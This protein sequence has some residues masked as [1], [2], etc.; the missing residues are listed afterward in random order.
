MRIVRALAVEDLAVEDFVEAFADVRDVRERFAV[1]VLEALEDVD[2]ARVVLAVL[3]DLDADADFDFPVEAA[4]V[5]RVEADL[6]LVRV[7]LVSVLVDVLAVDLVDCADVA[8]FESFEI[9]TGF[10]A[11]FDSDSFDCE[12]CDDFSI[13]AKS[14]DGMGLRG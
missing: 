8:V 10:A 6:V 12:A 4:D 3:A 14:P 11:D 9:S 2:F 13:A 7:D 1:V 5:A